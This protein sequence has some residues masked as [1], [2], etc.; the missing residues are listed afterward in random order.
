MYQFTEVPGKKVADIKLF[1][2]STCPWCR[3]TKNFL[4]E[5]DIEY[6]YVDIDT[7][8]QQDEMDA[9]KDLMKYNA[10]PAFPTLVINGSEVIVGYQPDKLEQLIA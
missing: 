2:L 1:A 8:D 9:A 5:H 10:S 6:E 7:L 3:R 4:N